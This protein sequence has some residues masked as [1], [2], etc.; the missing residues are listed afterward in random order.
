LAQVDALISRLT[1][2]QTAGE[3]LLLD[4]LVTRRRPLDI[5]DLLAWHRG[6]PP[7]AAAAEAPHPELV[8]AV[9]LSPTPCQL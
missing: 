2:G 3:A 6:L 7:L 4:D 9:L 8:A 1:G 5:R